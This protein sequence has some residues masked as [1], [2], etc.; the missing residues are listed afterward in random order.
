MREIKSILGEIEEKKREEITKTFE[1][2]LEAIACETIDWKSFLVYESSKDTIKDMLLA[3]ETQYIMI[4][5]DQL[6]MENNEEREVRV[7]VLEKK[8]EDVQVWNTKGNLDLVLAII[9][10]SPKIRNYWRKK[11]EK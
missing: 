3:M 2:C 4:I 9:E 6:K 10:I 1:M 7:A 5:C 11:A 8:E